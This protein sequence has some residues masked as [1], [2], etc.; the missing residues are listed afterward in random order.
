MDL[1]DGVL[2]VMAPL[3]LTLGAVAGSLRNRMDRRADLGLQPP[4][5]RHPVVF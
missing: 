3:A 1:R 5:T 4:T 2:I